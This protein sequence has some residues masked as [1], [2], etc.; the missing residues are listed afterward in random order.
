[1]A[2]A[3]IKTDEQL[4]QRILDEKDPTKLVALIELYYRDKDRADRTPR[5]WLYFHLGAL[6][7]LVM[8]LAKKSSK[9]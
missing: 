4:R 7:A 6:S 9:T 5:E 3:A 1:M 8:R 2:K